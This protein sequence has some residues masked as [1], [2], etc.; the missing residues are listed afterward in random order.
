MLQGVLLDRGVLSESQ[1]SVRIPPH[2][3]ARSQGT[4]D[5]R[6]SGSE[7]SEPSAPLLWGHSVPSVGPLRCSVLTGLQDLA[8][9]DPTAFPGFC[10][11]L[12]LSMLLTVLSPLSQT[13]DTSDRPPTQSHC[14]ITPDKYQHTP[15]GL[16]TVD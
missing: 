12:A 8:G 15:T 5:Q 2:A 14:F 7:P 11:F 9:S 13:T 4:G 16:F 1:K 6:P 3:V 10:P